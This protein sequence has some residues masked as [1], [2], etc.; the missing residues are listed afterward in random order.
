MKIFI[1]NQEP[2]TVTSKQGRQIMEQVVKKAEFV[3]VNGEMIRTS[4]IMSARND[5]G[6]ES[7]KSD[8]GALPAG[9]M[10]H[11]F[12]DRREAKGDG[13]AKY[14]AMKRKLLDR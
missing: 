9:R 10:K 7:P 12:D 14:Q 4:A 5:E 11:F 1:V 2:L 13:Y 8:W 6:A 3:V